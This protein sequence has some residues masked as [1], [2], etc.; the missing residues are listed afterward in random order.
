M[1]HFTFTVTRETTESVTVTVE[2][3]SIKEAHRKALATQYG[4][5]GWAYDEGNH[6]REAYIPDE[7]DYKEEV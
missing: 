4:I 1:P 2:A 7:D 6:P 5:R 3:D